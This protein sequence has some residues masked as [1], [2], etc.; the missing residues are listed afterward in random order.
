MCEKYIERADAAVEYFSSLFARE[1]ER[2]VLGLYMARRWRSMLDYAELDESEL[3]LF[4]SVLEVERDSQGSG[5][6]DLCVNVRNWVEERKGRVGGA[7][8]TQ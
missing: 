4:V 1:G 5:W 2:W 3:I 7:P 8:E 6:L